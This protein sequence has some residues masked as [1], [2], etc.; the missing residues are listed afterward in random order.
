[1]K[2][3]IVL[4]SLLLLCS[5]QQVLADCFSDLAYLPELKPIREK[6]ALA[7]VTEQTFGMLTD[8]NYR[9]PDEAPA[10][11]RWHF[12]RDKCSRMRPPAS[13][14]VEQLTVQAFNSIQSM[15]PDLYEGKMTYGEFAK[16]RQSIANDL[17]ARAQ[18]MFGQYQQQQAQQQQYQ[19]QREDYLDQACLNRAR[20][21]IERA[22]CSIGKGARQIGG[23]LL[24]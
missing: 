9:T 1:M 14:P 4:A 11:F 6:V 12:E 19:Q 20:N 22:E 16:R 5:S 8:N 17:D 13:N 7:S 18:Q 24:R 23:A 3:R 2:F 15:L 10:I 21:Q